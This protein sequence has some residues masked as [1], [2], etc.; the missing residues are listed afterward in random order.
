MMFIWKDGQ[1]NGS[2][3]DGLA[4]IYNDSLKTKKL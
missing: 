4:E 2:N 1:F 3:V